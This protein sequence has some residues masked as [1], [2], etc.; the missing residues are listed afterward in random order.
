M[1]CIRSEFE[2]LVGS[3]GLVGVDL[4]NTDVVVGPAGVKV[5][6]RLGPGEGGAAEE[7]LG[8]GL[9]LF[10]G[11][12]DDVFLDE[13]LLGEV[14]DLDAGLGGN[15]EP[16]ETLGEEDGVDGGVAVVLGEPLALDDVPNHDLAVTGAG[17]EE[18]GVLDDI[19]GRDLSLVTLAGVEEGHVE[20]IP[21]LDGLIPRG[22][23]AE[24]GLLGVVETDNGDGISVLV[25]LDGVL[26]LGAG[27]PDLDVSIERA[28]DDLSVVSGKGNGE[29]VSLVTNEL[30]D[31][32][33]GGNVPK[34]HSAVP[35][36]RESEARVAG[37]LDFRDEMR[38]TGHHLLG[39][40]PFGVTLFLTG[41]LE[42]P[43]DEGSVTGAREKELLGLTVDFLLTD[44]EG[45]D[46]T[47]VA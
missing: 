19:E 9:V 29:N 25:L 45:G 23:D 18:G 4:V 27:V 14:E 37:E 1:S 7:L 8:G 11:G 24:S 17:G 43:L 32:G 16:V 10:L 31:G 34:T 3:A 15:D 41:G 35:G 47:T 38:V 42:S 30:G 2:S 21:D 22:G 33:A 13:L 6:A 28:S 39:L 46:P 20:V 36:G 40:T 44:S 12:G 26:A 5:S